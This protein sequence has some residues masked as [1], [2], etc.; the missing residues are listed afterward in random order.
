[1][2][3]NLR[4][5]LGEAYAPREFF[6]AHCRVSALQVDDVGRSQGAWAR[7][8]KPR[9][10]SRGLQRHAD[11]LANQWVSFRGGIPD[12]RNARNA[13]RMNARSERTDG[14][15]VVLSPSRTQCLS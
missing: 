1:V 10:N 2:H 9:K 15:P 5:E 12:P 7:S 11:T 14:L 4:I 8:T 13:P 3:G 6:P